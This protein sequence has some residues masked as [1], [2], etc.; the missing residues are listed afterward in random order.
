MVEKDAVDGKHAVGL[1]IVL[2]HPVA[3]DL[4]RPIRRTGIERS[5]LILWRRG[6]AEHLGRGCL[7]EAGFNTGHAHSFQKPGSAN[8]SRVAGVL[9]FVK[10]N[11]DV[12]LGPQVVDFVRA[13]F[14]QQGHQPGAVGKVPIVEEKARFAVMRVHVEVI[15]AGR[16][17]GRGAT[18]QTV[19]LIAF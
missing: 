3:V 10:G 5:C 16:I 13:D 4:G 1:P 17:K 11:P 12:R 14:S 6:S 8:S 9:R 19:N 18:D 2:G 15:D 7:V